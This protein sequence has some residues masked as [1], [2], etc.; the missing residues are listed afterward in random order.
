MAF[1]LGPS[2]WWR[3]IDYEIEIM[4]TPRVGLDGFEGDP[5][6]VTSGRPFS[7]WAIHGRFTVENPACFGGSSN[8][9]FIAV[10]PRVGDPG[11]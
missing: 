10:P 1:A 9:P 11:G 7:A 3:Q 2:P 4:R 5:L 6:C 8:P